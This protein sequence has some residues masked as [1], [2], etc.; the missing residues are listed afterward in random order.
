MW[1]YHAKCNSKPDQQ[2]RY[3]VDELNKIKN[4]GDCDATYKVFYENFADLQ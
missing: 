1:E 4:A 2:N 3:M